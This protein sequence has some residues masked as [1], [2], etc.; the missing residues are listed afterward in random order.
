G[1]C[2]VRCDYGQSP[3]GCRPGY[4]CTTVS[5]FSEPG[6]V[7]YACVPGDD[8]PFVLSACHQELLARGVGFCPALSPDESP[9]GL[10]G[11]VCEIE[12]PIW[13]SPVLA[14]VAFRPMG[15]GEEPEAVFT[16]CPHGLAMLGAAE[17]LAGLGVNDV[18]HLGVYNCRVIAGTETLSQH[19]L[20]MAI[21][22]ALVQVEGGPLYSVLEDWEKNQPSPKTEGGKLLRAFAQTMFDQGVY[23]I[24][25][26]PDYNE[27]HADHF[28]CDLT[29]GA[30]YFK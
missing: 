3:T 10:P 20:A 15:I 24:I 17:I 29:E 13:I 18:V 27:A 2:T 7:V 25:L 28:H 21:D 12:D 11:V 9:E 14:G 26:T 6:T 30:H 4:Q 16:A 23:N 8:H 5:R 22:Y 1:L 19:G